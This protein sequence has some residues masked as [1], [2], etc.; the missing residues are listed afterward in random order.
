MDHAW[1]IKKELIT[2]H[3][4]LGQAIGDRHQFTSEQAQHRLERMTPFV[5]QFPRNHGQA[6]PCHMG[7]GVTLEAELWLAL[8]LHTPLHSDR[9]ALGNALHTPGMNAPTVPHRLPGTSSRHCS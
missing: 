8:A 2:E 1:P 7:L 3:Q 6:G 9:E 4:N 5:M